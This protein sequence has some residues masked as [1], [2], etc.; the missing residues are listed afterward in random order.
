[1]RDP[2]MGY[3]SGA[4]GEGICPRFSTGWH[5]TSL[6]APFTAPHRADCR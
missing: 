3:P 1:M 5:A 4:D 6:T 2:G